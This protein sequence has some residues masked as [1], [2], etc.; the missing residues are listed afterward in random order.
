MA[1][2]NE[3]WEIFLCTSQTDN[4]NVLYGAACL[5]GT[6]ED[7]TL[8]HMREIDGLKNGLHHRDRYKQGRYV[9]IWS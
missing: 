9:T 6:G 8:R 5:R 3:G 2:W 7:Q 1:P 4:G